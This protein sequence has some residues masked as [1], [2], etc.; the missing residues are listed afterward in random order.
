MWQLYFRISSNKN[1]DD[2]KRK[3]TFVVFYQKILDYCAEN[4]I[5][6]FAFEQKCGL[7]NGLVSKW[8]NGGY[9]SIQTLRKISEATEISIETWVEENQQTEKKGE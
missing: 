1:Q 9:P 6:I 7:P 8:K 4:S 5:S 3:E 2:F